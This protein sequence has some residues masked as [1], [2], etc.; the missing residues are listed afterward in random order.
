MTLDARRARLVQ[1]DVGQ[2]VR[3]V[4]RH[5]HE[6][7]VSLGVDGDGP[8][9][10]RGDEAVHE[11]EAL[12]RSRAGRSQEPRR[13]FEQLGGGAFGSSRLGAADRMTADEA[14]VSAG[15]FADGDL[16]RADIRHCGRFGREGQ[17]LA[18]LGRKRR[19]G[20]CHEHQVGL[21]DRGREI[22]SRLDGSPLHRDAKRIRIGVPAGDALDACAASGKRGGRADQTRADD[23]QRTERRCHQPRIS[24]ATRNARSSD[25]RA[26]SR[27]SQSV[28]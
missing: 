23:G 1:Q 13:T 4:A 3:E 6:A 22:V 16:G 7:V 28:S 27:G 8:G 24:S 26:F 5:G 14:R 15:G 18:D 11:P 12:G 10:E 20:R 21:A 2:S 19:D 9:T 25:C 17:R